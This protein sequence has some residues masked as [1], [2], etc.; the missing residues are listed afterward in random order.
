MRTIEGIENTIYGII[1]TEQSKD[2]NFDAK[3][4]QDFARKVAKRII[5]FLRTEKNL[6]CPPIEKIKRPCITE[7]AIKKL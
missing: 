4:Q 6:V 5:K 2:P 1:I 3:I 7:R